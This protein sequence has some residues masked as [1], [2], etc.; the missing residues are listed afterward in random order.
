[1]FRKNKYEINNQVYICVM[2]FLQKKNREVIIEIAYIKKNQVKIF[3]KT[4][5]NLDK[6]NRTPFFIF[7]FSNH[8][9]YKATIKKK[10]SI[11]KIT[12]KSQRH[13]I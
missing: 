3:K 6:T 11:K 8:N 7:A 2:Q 13:T 10:R 5:H 4:L 12:I 9:A 1:M